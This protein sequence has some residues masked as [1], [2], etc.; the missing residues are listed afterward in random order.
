[1]PILP[2]LD[3]ELIRAVVTTKWGASGYRP[4]IIRTVE[5]YMIESN[6][7]QD[8]DPFELTFG[9]P[10]KTLTAL[11]RRDS[12]IHVQIFGIGVDVPYLMTGI[13]DDVDFNEQNSFVLTG[14]DR[15][16]IAA[17]TIAEPGL[18]R[19]Q[20]AN[21][22]IRKRATE[23][24]VATKFN[25]A[26][27]QTR[28]TFKTDGSETEWEFWYRLIRHEGMWLW[29]SSDGTLNSGK[30]KT[31][32]PTYFFGTP[33]LSVSA[34]AD[35]HWLPVERVGYRK[36]TQ[37]RVGDVEMFYHS[38]GRHESFRAEDL[39]TKD[40]VKRPLKF[41][42]SSH[43]HTKPQAK[44][45][46]YEE[47]FETKVGALEIKI[48]VPDIGIII[49]Q[50]NIA[51]L[52]I[53]E[54]DVGGDWFIVG[55]R[56]I[57]DEGGFMQ[58]VRL[59]EKGY[60]VSA[61]VPEEPETEKEPSSDP[62]DTGGCL[63]AQGLNI[64]WL[65]FFIN[66]AHQHR[67]NVDFALYL[68]TIIA[69]ADQESGFRNVR[70]GGQVEWFKWEGKPQSGITSRAEWEEA[71][72]NDHG[73]G[74]GGVGPMQLTDKPFKIAAD[75]FG[76]GP[77]DELTGNRWSPEAN[78]ME[79]ANV[80]KGKGATSEATLWD[81]VRAYNGSGSAAEAYKESVRRKV[82]NSP[83]YLKMIQDAITDCADEGEFG[84]GEKTECLKEIWAVWDWMVANEPEIH[85]GGP[86]EPNGHPLPGPYK[87]SPPP[88][89]LWLDCSSAVSF[90]NIQAGVDWSEGTSFSYQGSGFKINES[91]IAEYSKG[92]LILAF[93]PNHVAAVRSTSQVYSHGQESGPEIRSSVRYRTDFQEVRAYKVCK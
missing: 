82:Y 86:D 52:N 35:H 11:L 68:A 54:I 92:H 66:A 12:E 25:L 76:G 37:P 20:R 61:R 6:L 10:G 77:V 23:L 1:M 57:A 93:Y 8:S 50:N 45:A 48:L 71:F 33:P 65:Q 34:G 47:I 27:E 49:Q 55:T 74:G 22:F 89:P 32:A 29:F 44:K 72:K 40:W 2:A 7:D 26:G 91:Q 53:P 38:G 5:S 83:G 60:A 21:D 41:L 59:R 70:Q 81:A 4:G 63:A 19:E 36:T 42:E 15:S 56:I 69:I 31:G 80:L 46:V 39:T 43:I 24:K 85:Y 58:E 28:K 13:A 14:R 62:E 88:L 3:P 51:R 67:S 75:Q 18:W 64:R 84:G 79:G 16:S 73:E 90:A 87:Q 17:D 78:I 30:L 9:D